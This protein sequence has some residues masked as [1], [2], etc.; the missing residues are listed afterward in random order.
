MRKF[1]H[2]CLK[3]GIKPEKATPASHSVKFFSS[4]TLPPSCWYQ[5]LIKYAHKKSNFSLFHNK[6]FAFFS[7]LSKPQHKQKRTTRME[8]MYIKFV[9]VISEIPFLMAE[10]ANS[11]IVFYPIATRNFSLLNFYFW[12]QYFGEY[13]LVL[14]FC[15]F[16][17][18]IL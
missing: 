5:L 18:C 2:Q 8:I 12:V 13:V 4:H 6:K 7:C 14:S 9:S 10:S 11:L 1:Q 15:R 17:D 3:K 16:M